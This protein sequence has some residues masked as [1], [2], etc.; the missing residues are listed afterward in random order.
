MEKLADLLQTSPIGIAV[1]DS[2]L[3]YVHI[4][5]QLADSN[6]LSPEEHIGRTRA[7]SCPM[8]APGWK[9]SCAR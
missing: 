8:S 7:T 5:H 1:L 6:G 9:T 4:N 2:Q 3:R